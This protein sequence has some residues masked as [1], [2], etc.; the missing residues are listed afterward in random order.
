ML[1]RLRCRRQQRDPLRLSLLQ[2]TRARHCRSAS[3]G[4]S[5]VR[6]KQ[7]NP[8]RLVHCTVCGACKIISMTQTIF[9]ALCRCRSGS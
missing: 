9:R 6:R 5:R 8:R 7:T 2:L 4:K 1:G 3:V